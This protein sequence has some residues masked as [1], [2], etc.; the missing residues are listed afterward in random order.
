MK[1][2]AFILTLLTGCALTPQDLKSGGT[3]V[4]TETKLAPD[5]AAHCIQRA[6]ENQKAAHNVR[7]APIGGGSYE[8]LLRIEPTAYIPMSSE[9]SQMLF[10]L[11]PI[12]GGTT[13]IDAW[14]SGSSTNRT[15]AGVQGL[16]RG[17][18]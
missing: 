17:C 11:K 1:K 2:I 6:L 13:G 7:V 14:L 16:L 3:H 12:T 4:R 15:E 18:E 10:E 5:R 8:V 9:G